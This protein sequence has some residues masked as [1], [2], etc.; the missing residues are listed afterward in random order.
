MSALQ[1]I[2]QLLFFS[3]FYICCLSIVSCEQKTKEAPATDTTEELRSEPKTKENTQVSELVL[4]QM[5]ESN[6]KVVAITQKALELKVPKN[7]RMIL[8]EIEKD[9][10]QLKNQIR[11]IAKHNFIII[12]N[13]LYDTNTLKDFISE[14]S[15]DK[16]LQKLKKTLTAELELYKKITSSTYNKDLLDLTNKG[17]ISIEKNIASI[18]KEQK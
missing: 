2:K 4:T 16:Y 7:T 15:I 3:L 9:H 8:Q 11:K 13:I 1:Y 12:P 18:D 5:A 6:L 14:S 10:N 17:I